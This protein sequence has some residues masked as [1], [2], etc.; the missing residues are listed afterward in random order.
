[1]STFQDYRACLY[2]E[3]PDKERIIFEQII[4]LTPDKIARK[5]GRDANPI[6]ECKIIESNTEKHIC[7]PVKFKHSIFNDKEVWLKLGFISKELG[8]SF[9][10]PSTEFKEARIYFPKL[11]CIVSA[12]YYGCVFRSTV[13]N[14]IL[15]SMGVELFQDCERNSLYAIL[16]KMLFAVEKHYNIKLNMHDFL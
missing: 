3:F 4:S 12:N 8:Y 6:I 1:M 11:D 13:N 10:K 9:Y 7:T 14:F 2:Y 5:D 16:E 15:S